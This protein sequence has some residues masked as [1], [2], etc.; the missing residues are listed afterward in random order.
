VAFLVAVFALFFYPM[1]RPVI[2]VESGV[3]RSLAEPLSPSVI[4]T[5]AVLLLICFAACLEAFRRGSRMDKILAC[6]ALLV[7]MLFMAEFLKSLTL[8][9][10]R[11]P[12]L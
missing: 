9:S 10:R 12:N 11:T 4:A 3:G 5:G 8:A 2:Y 6:V 1:I 7:T